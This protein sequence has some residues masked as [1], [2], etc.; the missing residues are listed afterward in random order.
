MTERTTRDHTRPSAPALSSI[1][2]A[3]PRHAQGVDAV[4]EEREHGRQERQRRDDRDDADEDRSGR[5]APEDRV[6]NEHHPDHREHEGRAAEQHGAARRRPDRRRSRRAS[7][8]RAAAPRGSGRRRRASSR[9]RGRGPSPRSCSPR[10]PRDRTPG[11]RAAVSPSA[12]TIETSATSTGSS[13]ATTAPKTSSRTRSATGS[14]NW[15]SPFCRSSSESVEKSSVGGELAGD[16]GLE[17]L[18][19]GRVDDLDDPLDRCLAVTP[20]P[21][22]DHRRASA[23]R[24]EGRVTRRVP[25]A[26]G[27]HDGVS[28]LDR[29]RERLDLRAEGRLARPRRRGA[30]DDELV[31][32]RR[33]PAG[34]ALAVKSYARY[35]S[36][37]FV[38]SASVVS[39]SP[40]R[41]PIAPTERTRT[42][43]QIA[44]VRHGRPAHARARRPVG[45]RAMRRL[46]S[47]ASSAGRRPG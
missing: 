36:G 6:G 27:R 35:D 24:D 22:R 34:S 11:R 3:E 5:E 29:P 47:R 43:P 4:A 19:L 42:T 7:R 9:S 37:S 38:I 18:A 23:R 20:K 31:H 28:A 30:N 2:P 21:D 8:F 13:P 40:S 25:G 1:A 39:A 12:T 10:R 41:P 46:S 32:V 33:R 17:P 16:R 44:S 15:S 14:P 45:S 26:D